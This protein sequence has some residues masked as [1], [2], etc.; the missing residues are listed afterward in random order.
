MSRSETVRIR[1]YGRVQGVFFRSWTVEQAQ[2]LGLSGWVRNRTDGTV[3]AVA[4]GPSDLVDQL[5]TRIREGGPPA[6]EVEEV[7]AAPESQPP[8]TSG[9]QQAATG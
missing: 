7:E 8:E 3:E 1:V 6:A 9:F 4:H 2:A 5:I